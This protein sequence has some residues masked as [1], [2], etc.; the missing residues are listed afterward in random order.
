MLD[1]FPPYFWYAVVAG[2]IAVLIRRH[3]RRRR[4]NND[5]H[6]LPQAYE[7]G[8][9]TLLA[10]RPVNERPEFLL[11]WAISQMRGTEIPPLFDQLDK[12]ELR[13]AE[14]VHSAIVLDAPA[15]E[16]ARRRLNER[17]GRFLEDFRNIALDGGNSLLQDIEDER[18]KRRVGRSLERPFKQVDELL[19]WLPEQRDPDLWHLLV[20][21]LNYDHESA[22]KVVEWIVQ[23]PECDRATAAL[24]LIRISA[25]VY[26]SYETIDA[27]SDWDRTGWSIARIVS[28][29]SNRGDYIQQNLNLSCVGEDNDQSGMQDMLEREASRLREQGKK[30]PWPVPSRLFSQPFSGRDAISKRYFVNDDTL[31]HHA[32]EA[33]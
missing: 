20:D 24:A 28:D 13:A 7:R 31:Y 6:Q 32:D 21:G 12:R 4:Q 18:K 26:M 25:D 9:K 11:P 27:C 1:R 15:F 33:A 14:L 5:L 17:E 10:N 3:F 29:R 19:A 2:S 22:W 23:Q 16:A 8:L 30:L